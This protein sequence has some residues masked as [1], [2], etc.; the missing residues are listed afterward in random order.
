[1]P[2]AYCF[3]VYLSVSITQDEE[4]KVDYL[5][6]TL[7]SNIKKHCNKQ[8]HSLGLPVS[9][10]PVVYRWHYDPRNNDL[11]CVC[12]AY[13]TKERNGTL[14]QSFQN[15]R[16]IPA[17][18]LADFTQ[19][20]DTYIVVDRNKTEIC[21]LFL[22][23]TE[24]K[25]HVEF[26]E[27]SMTNKML[28]ITKLNLLVP[29]ALVNESSTV[30]IQMRLANKLKRAN[31]SCRFPVQVRNSYAYY[32]PSHMLPIEKRFKF[33]VTYKQSDVEGLG[34]LVSDR[35]V[36]NKVKSY[37]AGLIESCYGHRI[38]DIYSTIGVLME[39]TKV[40]VWELIRELMYRLN[41]ARRDQ[42]MFNVENTLIPK[43]Y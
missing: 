19:Y 26:Q 13:G 39:P 18:M 10:N 12:D 32:E 30:H 21:R 28:Y 6:G 25:C 8:G 3:V 24:A 9:A 36:C 17:M 23:R 40:S 34:K 11:M 20:A 22:D 33:T 42:C 43:G 27:E 35:E 31:V 37:A 15:A 7:G 41:L 14:V 29:A 2:F 38:Y 16:A 4:P 5:K 1:M